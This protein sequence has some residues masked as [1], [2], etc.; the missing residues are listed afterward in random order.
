VSV[1]SPELA[2]WLLRPEVVQLAIDS[3][4]LER[5]LSLHLQDQLS[6]PGAFCMQETPG[7]CHVLFVNQ[8]APGGTVEEGK[9]VFL[10]DAFLLPMSWHEGVEHSVCLPN[11]FRVLAEELVE[12]LGEGGRWGLQLAPTL[13]HCDLRDLGWTAAS[14]WASLAVGLLM[15]QRNLRPRRDVFASVAWSSQEGVRSVEGVA[16]KAAVAREFGAKSLFVAAG[17]NEEEL[18]REKPS[19]LDVHTFPLGDSEP[20]R[21]L[22]VLLHK[23]Q[24]EPSRKDASL[25]RRIEYANAFV[26]G[27]LRVQREAY[28]ATQLTRELVGQ[29]VSIEHPIAA[30]GVILSARSSALF[31]IL[32]CRPAR[33]LLLYTERDGSS[34]GGQAS[35][36]ELLVDDLKREVDFPC[37][38]FGLQVDVDDFASIAAGILAF[39]GEAKAKEGLSCLDVTGGKTGMKVHALLAAQT[40]PDMGIYFINSQQAKSSSFHEVG[41]ECVSWLQGGEARRRRK[42]PG[43]RLLAQHE[44][45][46]CKA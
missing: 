45:I 10:R 46:W 32:S 26:D 1:F 41:T 31:S 2:I 14:G 29:Q 24:Q 19:G 34:R 38:V 17:R 12:S 43:E 11:E 15:A 22:G 30:L 25:E 13:A 35:T 21:V 9:L 7:A 5:K 42:Q 33:C 37:D 23:M 44:R 36:L 20:H 28:I 3:G 40:Q 8:D 6:D 16:Q 39:F 18:N 4:Q 27:R